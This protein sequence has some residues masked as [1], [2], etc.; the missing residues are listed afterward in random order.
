MCSYQKDDWESMFTILEH[1]VGRGELSW[2]HQAST[3]L[4]QV[5]D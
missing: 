1:V 2:K 5:C 4:V 3:A